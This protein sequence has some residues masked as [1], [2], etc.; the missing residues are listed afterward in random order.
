MRPYVEQQCG[1]TWL[2]TFSLAGKYYSASKPLEAMQLVTWDDY[3]EGSELE[4]GIDNHVAISGQLQGS[5]LHWTVALDAAAPDECVQAVAG[6]FDPASTLDHFTVYV[7]PSGDGEHL[8][9][10]ADGVPASAT[11][12]DLAGKLS[13]GSWDVFV[14]ATAKP[15]IRNHLS[16]AVPYVVSQ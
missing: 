10:V 3:E 5:T 15:S 13:A 16:G 2:D 4:T 9:L 7:S 1:K 12:I 8:T 11:S 14:Y 6:G